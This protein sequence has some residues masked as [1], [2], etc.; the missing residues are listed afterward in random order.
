MDPENDPGRNINGYRQKGARKRLPID[1][2]D[3]HDVR[4]RVI[5]LNNLQ[6]SRD[7]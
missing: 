1:V 7:F 2:I 4:R 6:R 3:Q 5:N